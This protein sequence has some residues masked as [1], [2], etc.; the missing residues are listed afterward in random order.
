M[1]P[2]LTTT[3]APPAHVG[4]ATLATPTPQATPAAANHTGPVTEPG[5]PADGSDFDYALS[6]TPAADAFLDQLEAELHPRHQ[7]APSGTQYLQQAPGHLARTYGDLLRTGTPEAAAVYRKEVTVA[8]ERQSAAGGM[9][10]DG[11]FGHVATFLR[12][13]ADLM[14]LAVQ[15]ADPN[16][17]PFAKAAVERHID[18]G[19]KMLQDQPGAPALTTTVDDVMKQAGAERVRRVEEVKDFFARVDEGGRIKSV[20]FSRDRFNAWL[21][22]GRYIFCNLKDALAMA[23]RPIIVGYHSLF[24]ISFKRLKLL[25]YGPH[26]FHGPRPTSLEFVDKDFVMKFYHFQDESNLATIHTD[27]VDNDD[28]GKDRY[29]LDNGPWLPYPEPTTPELEILKAAGYATLHAKA[30]AAYQI[31]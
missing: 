9:R 22:D 23:P 16:T 6:G 11:W 12:R 24:P 3:S 29:R 1:Y 17:L 26:N 25:E 31:E 18:R 7:R 27:C 14:A 2:A 30:Q 5:T 19:L 13:S 28:H 4:F 10:I 15:K 21:R 8:F 20:P